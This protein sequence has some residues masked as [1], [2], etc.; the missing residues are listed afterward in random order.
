MYLSNVVVESEFT[1]SI[2][3]THVGAAGYLS[4]ALF[5][6]I[7]NT[8]NNKPYQVLG[9]NFPPCY[10]SRKDNIEPKYTFFDKKWKRFSARLAAL[11]VI[12]V[13]L[14]P[15]WSVF[16]LC[17]S[18]CLRRD[19]YC[20]GTEPSKRVRWDVVVFIHKLM[21]HLLLAFQ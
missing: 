20:C 18:W 15:W 19:L 8:Q 10:N 4:V 2:S 7:S 1:V 21:K 16:Q 11:A 9:W 17:F 13:S 12:I 3:L 14:F 6:N 5:N